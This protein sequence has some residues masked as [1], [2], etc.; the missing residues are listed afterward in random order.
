MGGP[1]HI[2]NSTFND[3]KNPLNCLLCLACFLSW[4]HYLFYSPLIAQVVRV[5]GDMFKD[6]GLIPIP[7]L[8]DL[9]K[10]PPPWQ[11]KKKR[12]SF[13]EMVT[14]WIHSL[15]LFF[16]LDKDCVS[17][18][19]ACSKFQLVWVLRVWFLSTMYT[20]TLTKKK[21]YT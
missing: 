10:I 16:L 18:C 20:K 9:P 1:A 2:F 4:D 11:K 12:S 13:M 15:L 5:L 7:T 3:R 21:M 17:H 8:S 14:W 6:E 19:W